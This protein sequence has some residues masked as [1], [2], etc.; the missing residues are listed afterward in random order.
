VRVLMVVR[1]ASGGMKEHVLALSAGLVSAGHSVELAAPADADVLR[2]ARDSGVATHPIPLVGPLHPLRDARAIAALRRV[3]L[4][5]RFDIV[6]AHGFKAGLVARLAVPSR[7]RTREAPAVV[8]T[9]HNHVLFRDDTS[10]AKKRLYRVV[11]RALAPRAARYIAVSDSIRRE[12][13][14]GYGLPA[15]KVTV[16]YNGVDPAPFLA[17][18]DRHAARSQLGLSPDAAVVG[19]AAR[20]SAQKGLRHLIAAIPELRDG[21]RSDGRD[22]IVAIGG[23]GPLERELHEQAQVLGVSDSIRWLGHV[24]SVP[25][26][27]ASL[28]VYVSPAE[29]EALGI[30]LIEA[31]LA[32]VPIVATNVGGVP[33]VILEGE[34]GVL[35]SPRQ[36]VLLAREALGLLRDSGRSSALG[37][38]ARERCL[39]LFSPALMMEHTL[40]AYSAATTRAGGPHA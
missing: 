20:F 32:A 39:H 5:G 33:E 23:S 28:D 11:E 35:V 7:T 9:A 34:T 24:E 3:V 37:A 2:A 1:P 19:L 29:T 22:L 13:V 16:V 10:A 18:R 8:V 17:V 30:G 40:D 14:D 26:L 31:S 6:H 4:A 38:A 36:P 25:V 27:L 15:D 12:L 21:L